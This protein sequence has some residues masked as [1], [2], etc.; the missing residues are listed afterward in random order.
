M[1]NDRLDVTLIIIIIIILGGQSIPAG[2]ILT[3]TSSQCN[4][5]L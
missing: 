1:K 3:L 2:V 4:M 5:I